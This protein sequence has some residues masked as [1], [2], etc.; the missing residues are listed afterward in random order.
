[1]RPRR[2]QVTPLCLHIPSLPALSY[3]RVLFVLFVAHTPKIGMFL[4]PLPSLK[5]NRVAAIE[6]EGIFHL[7]RAQVEERKLP[8]SH[9]PYSAAASFC[10]GR[11]R[12]RTSPIPSRQRCLLIHRAKQK[13]RVHVI[14]KQNKNDTH[15]SR[16]HLPWLVCTSSS[17]MREAPPPPLHT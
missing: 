12:R 1:M 11:N 8:L 15:R 16:A 17:F 6:Y 3:L 10:Q 13:G 7:R 14:F 9:I 2:S 5:L 4:F